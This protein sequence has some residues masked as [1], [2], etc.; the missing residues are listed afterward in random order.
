[1]LPSSLKNLSATLSPSNVLKHL[2]TPLDV[3]KRPAYYAALP[4]R[5]SPQ[6]LQQM[7]IQKVLSEV[8]KEAIDEGE[9]DALINRKVKITISDA[10]ISWCLGL[11]EQRKLRISNDQES[12]TEIRGNSAALI[13]I[14][15]REMDPDTLFFQRQL[16][17]LGDTELG[18]E[19]KN[20]LDAIDPKQMPK[21]VQ[22]LQDQLLP[23]LSKLQR[24]TKRSAVSV[25]EAINYQESLMD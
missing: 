24:W 3:M 10:Q 9:F 21:A 5:Y 17:I 12:D 7:A 2:P 8:L 20:L 6:A 22:F 1:M 4:V 14:L 15:S 23:R 25:S 16:L 18:H 13:Q 11:N 19:V